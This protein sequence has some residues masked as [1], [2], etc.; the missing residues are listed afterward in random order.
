MYICYICGDNFL[1]ID[2]LLAH[3][4]SY[5]LLSSTDRLVCHQNNCFQIFFS[6]S[7][8]KKHLKFHVH[9]TPP[10]EHVESSS[11]FEIPSTRASIESSSSVSLEN[12]PTNI[13]HEPHITEPLSD[14]NETPQITFNV[15]GFKQKAQKNVE[16]FVTKLYSKPNLTTSV[17]ESILSDFTDIISN[18]LVQS[19]K[20]LII[21]LI[22]HNFKN[23]I[24]EI[25]AFCSQPFENVKTEY[26]FLQLLKTKYKFE[27][28]VKFEIHSE[29]TESYEN[30]VSVLKP[31]K[32]EGTLMP[33]VYQLKQFF[34]C[35]G[36]LHET[37]EYTNK[38]MNS[39]DNKIENFVQGRLWKE[40]RASFDK[41]EHVLPLIGYYD[42]FES[43]NP[44]GSHAGAQ[45]IA[46]FYFFCPSLS[47][48]P[49]ALHNIF[50]GCLIKSQD[51]KKFGPNISFSKMIDIFKEI[52][53]NGISMHINNEELNVKFVL[54]L[55]IGDNIALN[56]ILGYTGSFSSNFYCRICKEPKSICQIST[57]ENSENLRSMESHNE[58][59][60]KQP[61]ETGL[62]FDSYFNTLNHFHVTKNIY[63]DLMHDGFEGFIKFGLANALKYFIFEKK[64]ITLE[65]LNKN[66]NS[67]NYGEI[68][69][70]NR[71]PSIKEEHIKTRNLHMSA[72]ESY[73]FVKY[74][75]LIV[76]D[77]I[78]KDDIV[79][80]Y[81]LKLK[82]L[83]DFLLKDF[84]SN[85][86]I[87]CLKTLIMQHHEL[88]MNI[89][90]ENLKPKHHL[91]CHYPRIIE[92]CGPVKHISCMRL[93][94]KNKEIKE[95]AKVCYSRKNLPYTLGKKC[96]YKFAFQTLFDKNL[97]VEISNVNGKLK[98]KTDLQYFN[99]I[100]LS[101]FEETVYS[102]SKIKYK[103]V[104]FKSNYYIYLNESLY[105]IFDIIL[106]N[107][108][109][110]LVLEEFVINNLDPHL[111][112]F[113]IGV[114]KNIFCIEDLCFLKSTKPFQIHELA[115]EEQYFLPRIL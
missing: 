99:K 86:D 33:I 12:A 111:K 21:P 41:D 18:S 81:I 58:D 94:S 43:G 90:N 52:E 20:D 78:P 62:K 49:L 53:T 100:D 83:T 65:S 103:G 72:R 35:P 109:I 24:S 54:A 11:H 28:P 25:F 79:W 85:V 50:I 105:K 30:G 113:K 73:C 5:H 34:E 23:E 56:F 1:N 16:T 17:I 10:I 14:Y 44:L 40:K 68:E 80:T 66:L 39:C 88:Y 3:F 97:N 37:L 89:F 22:P 93:E 36:I 46:G 70:E 67:F 110:C 104:I 42:D 57:C 51:L 102:V 114:S 15:T 112:I 91:L 107:E 87:L 9:D 2:V 108:N 75:T 77:Y 38:L 4:S 63:S 95:Y 69:V 45:S 106:K 101:R 13:D 19:L 76:G 47:K 64:F 60:D 48:Y 98:L 6:R 71:P 82:E 7:A 61:S 84:F 8:F 26:L 74:I 115:N 59:L 27:G 92:N 32:Y 96:N 31:V 55:I 29:V